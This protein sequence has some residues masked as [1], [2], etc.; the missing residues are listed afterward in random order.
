V[1]TTDNRE[2]VPRSVHVI[3]AANPIGAPPASYL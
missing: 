2:V 3:G 1:T